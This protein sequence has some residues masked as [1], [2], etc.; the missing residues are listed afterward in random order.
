MNHQWVIKKHKVK[1]NFSVPF[2]AEAKLI[3][4]GMKKSD[5]VSSSFEINEEGND[6]VADLN[7][8]NYEIICKFSNSYYFIPNKFT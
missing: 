2:N 4:L 6:I 7:H 3:L 1:Y 5:V 8:G